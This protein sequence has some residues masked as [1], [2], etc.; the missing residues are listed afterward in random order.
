[1][2]FEFAGLQDPG[3][4]LVRLRF[5]KITALVLPHGVVFALFCQQLVMGALFYDLA[6]I[7]YNDAIH[8]QNCG[9]TLGYNDSGFS[10]D[11]IKNGYLD[12]LFGE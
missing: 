3:H 4:F 11:Q 6:F 9:K 2:F 5:E 8:A 7:Q 10:F 12:L 1:M